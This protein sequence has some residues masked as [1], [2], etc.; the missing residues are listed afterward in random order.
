MYEIT[1][2]HEILIQGY[3]IHKPLSVNTQQMSRIVLLAKDELDVTIEHK[4]MN[5]LVAS[6]WVKISQ[7]GMKN[8][9]VGGIYREHWLLHQP[10]DRSAHPAEQLN[11]WT[12]FME[13]VERASRN[14]NCNIIGDMNMDFQRWEE[15]DPNHADLINT[16]KNTMETEGFTQPVQGITRS[17]PGQLDSLIDQFWTNATQKVIKTTNE[18]RAAGDHNYITARH[19][20]KKMREIEWKDIYKL[21]D[22]RPSQ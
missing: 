1:P 14:T 19:T 4:Y 2:V 10:D 13:Q 12:M 9:L 5:E 18:V 11:R 16:T 21:Q 15:P 3:N 8:I 17:W 20:E 7:P 22:V 6:I